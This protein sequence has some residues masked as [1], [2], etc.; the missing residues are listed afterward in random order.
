MS[1]GCAS[2]AAGTRAGGAK[3]VPELFSPFVA[4]LQFCAWEASSG[5]FLS[6][7][8]TTYLD[9]VLSWHSSAFARACSRENVVV[10]VR[11]R[12]RGESIPQRL[13]GKRVVGCSGSVL[14]RGE[15]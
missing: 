8:G 14:R 1:D 13:K 15:I 11:R 2:G 10:D 6:A 4:P 5:V 3:F 7:A 12:G 9:T